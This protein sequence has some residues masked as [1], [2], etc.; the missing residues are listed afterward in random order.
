MPPELIAWI[1]TGARLVQMMQNQDEHVI[2]VSVSHHVL[3]LHC[4]TGS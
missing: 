4:G 1:Y 3:R 2:N